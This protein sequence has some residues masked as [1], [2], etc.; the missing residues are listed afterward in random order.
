M[1]A[2]AVTPH[3]RD[4]GRVV[5]AP[6]PKPEP[7]EALVRMVRAGIC[8]TD[9][10][11]NEGLYGEPPAGSEYLI[12]GHENLGR[13]ESAPSGANGLQAG[14]LVVSTVRRPDDCPNCKA[15]ESDMCIK[16]N[17]RERGIKGLHGYWAEYYAEVP[18]FMVRIPPELEDVAVL[19]EPLSVV[20]KAVAQAYKLQ[21]RMLWKPQTALVLGAGPIGLLGTLLLRTLGL[22]VVTAATRPPGDLKSQLV[23]ACG[24]EYLSVRQQPLAGLPEKLGNID[25]IIEATGVGSLAFEAMQIVGINGV[26]ALTSVSGGSAV[27]QVPADKLNLGFVLSN[28]VVFGSVNANRRYFESGV[29]HLAEFR[30]RWPGLLERAITRRLPLEGFHEGLQKDPDGIKTVLEIGQAS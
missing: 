13:V 27:A 8:G 14:E 17:Y 4:S 26:V 9:V 25:L 24:G 16:G 12:L 30:R 19:M 2:V 11:I 1:R 21:E 28:K 5:D 15:G 29:G 22:R 20:E 3:Q 10:E 6:E 23:E 7:G 18:A